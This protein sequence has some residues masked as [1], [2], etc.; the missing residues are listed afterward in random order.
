MQKWNIETL[1]NLIKNRLLLENFTSY[2]YDA[3]MQD[4]YVTM[5]FT[6]L[7]TKYTFDIKRELDN[8]KYNQKVNKSVFF[9]AIKSY[10]AGI[11]FLD[12]SQIN[13]EQMFE[14]LQKIF[15]TNRNSNKTTKK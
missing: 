10:C 3:I 13:K 9:N 5:L 7:E 12:E 11:F 1:Y 15:Y 2:S 8:T 4:F 14:N 6:N